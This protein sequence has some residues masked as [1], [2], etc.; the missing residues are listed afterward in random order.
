M[1]GKYIV[2][3]KSD[4]LSISGGTVTGDTYFSSNLSAET[5]YSGSTLLSTQ[6]IATG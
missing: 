6:L 4:Y 1:S 2:P 3:I 5:Y